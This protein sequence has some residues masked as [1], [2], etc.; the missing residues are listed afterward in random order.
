M[1]ERCVC[2]N[3]ITSY[4][5]KVIGSLTVIGI[6]FNM[7][8]MGNLKRQVKGRF[9]SQPGQGNNHES[10]GTMTVCND[11]LHR[12]EENGSNVWFDVSRASAPA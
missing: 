9:V 8:R 2:E 3:K 1:G 10:E 5:C 7:L 6:I 11:S 4:D 12:Q